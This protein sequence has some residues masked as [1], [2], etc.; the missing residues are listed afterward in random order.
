MDEHQPPPP[1]PPP[2]PPTGF[3]NMANIFLFL[4]DSMLAATPLA[5]IN[6]YI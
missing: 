1:P 3:W 5:Y 6:F 4:V 2:P